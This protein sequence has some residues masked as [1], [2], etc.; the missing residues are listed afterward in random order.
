MTSDISADLLGT[1]EKGEEAVK[2]FVRER[3]DTDEQKN[4]YALLCQDLCN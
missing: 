2:E 1:H 3:L 4:F